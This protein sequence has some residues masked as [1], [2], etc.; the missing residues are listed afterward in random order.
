MLT[1]DVSAE[2]ARRTPTT[3]APGELH[4]IGNQVP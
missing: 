4:G 3:D 2:H 1:A